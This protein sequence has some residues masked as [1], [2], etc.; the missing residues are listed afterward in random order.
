MD[1]YN[2][3][4]ARARNLPK[5]KTKPKIV[6]ETLD[7]ECPKVDKKQRLEVTFYLNGKW[8]TLVSLPWSRPPN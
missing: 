6:V 8:H 4:M 5:M 1:L 2:E 7:I 3:R